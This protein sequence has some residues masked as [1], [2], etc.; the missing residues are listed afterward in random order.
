MVF[1]LMLKN[2][3]NLL[4]QLLKKLKLLWLIKCERL[5][6]NQ[7]DLNNKFGSIINDNW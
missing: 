1:I 7:N 4:M 6:I 3:T 2:T 5:K